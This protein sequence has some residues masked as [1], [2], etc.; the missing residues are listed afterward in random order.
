MRARVYSSCASMHNTPVLTLWQAAPSCQHMPAAAE[1]AGGWCPCLLALPPWKDSSGQGAGACISCAARPVP[2]LPGQPG[3]IGGPALSSRLRLGGRPIGELLE[4]LG[5][6]LCGAALLGW[7]QTC[8]HPR[9]PLSC[10]VELRCITLCTS[11]AARAPRLHL[12]AARPELSPGH[13]H[14]TRA[15]TGQP[16]CVCTTAVRLAPA[17]P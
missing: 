17:A 16:V 1:P 8:A 11:R 14:S 15:A 13:G 9:V 4:L 6:G 5:G 10:L 2:H 3:L 7:A 12:V